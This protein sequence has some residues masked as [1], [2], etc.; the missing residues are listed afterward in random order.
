MAAELSRDLHVSGSKEETKK[1]PLRQ[2][3]EERKKLL[4][5][6]EEMWRQRGQV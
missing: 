3:R 6:G 5:K 1:T 2:G 4:S